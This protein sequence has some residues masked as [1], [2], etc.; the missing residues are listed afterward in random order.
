MRINNSQYENKCYSPDDLGSSECSLDQEKLKEL[1]ELQEKY[2]EHMVSLADNPKESR[3]FELEKI[4]PKT[5]DIETL[6]EQTTDLKKCLD[7]FRPLDPAQVENLRQVFDLE[8]T[9]NS[10]RIEGNTLTLRETMFVV[11][12]GMTIEGKPL[13]D[14]FEAVNHQEGINYI[15]ELIEKDIPLSEDVIKQIQ[16]IILTRIQDIE[17]HHIG[18]YRKVEVRIA[19]S[20]HI[21]PTKEKVP[22]EMKKYIDFYEENKETMNPVLL[23]S[24][25]HLRLVDIHPF[26]DGNGRTA[27]LVMNLILLQNGYP[28]S[29]ISSEK[30]ERDDYYN[31]L[32]IADV[33]EDKTLFH[34]LILKAVKKSLF[35][36]LQ[37]VPGGI[38][39]KEEKKGYYFFQK[40][41]DH[42]T[43]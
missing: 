4:Y 21:P 1:K 19:G 38:G 29:I 8:Y 5:G 11:E 43:N 36:Y 23:A 15:R 30:K 25:M 42:L 40:I 35:N 27:R 31:A 3:F 32:L 41:K 24:E 20:P 22:G 33:D 17:K 2:R 34:R 37:M 13:K 18:D 26:V 14:H 16:G 12:K 6:I 10:N 28:L 39:E 7:S 9:Y